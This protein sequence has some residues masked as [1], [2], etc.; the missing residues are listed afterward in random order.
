MFKDNKYT[1]WY[2]MIVSQ[3]DSGATYTERHHIVP[4]SLGGANTKDN[5][6]NLSARQ[7]FVAHLLL[8]KMTEGEARSKMLWALHRMAFSKNAHHERRFTSAE[9]AMVRKIFA[10]HVRASQKGR[11]FSEETLT[12]MR[13]SSRKRWDRVASGL[14]HHPTT[15]GYRYKQTKKRKQTGPLSAETRA[16]MAA[17][18]W[19]SH[20]NFAPKRVRPDD[21]AAHQL[22]GWRFGRERKA[23][24]SMP[25]R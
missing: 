11:T 23:Q 2:M 16:K 6:V 10:E 19:M 18:R 15:K 13:E 22:T 1:K 12:K 21:I 7:H 9:Y 5:L 8:T 17:V 14:E 3:P 24:S 4:R 25:Q 20:D